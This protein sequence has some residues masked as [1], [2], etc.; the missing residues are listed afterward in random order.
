MI[1]L[2]LRQSPVKPPMQQV[3]DWL[4]GLGNSEYTQHFADNDM[5]F[6]IVGDQNFKD[7]GVG[8]VTPARFCG[9]SPTLT[10]IAE[11]TEKMAGC[12]R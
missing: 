6:S 2:R 1:S 9:R 8:S 5:N 10:A 7:L 3:T 11:V 12:P 4:E